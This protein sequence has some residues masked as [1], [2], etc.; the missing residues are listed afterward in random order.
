MRR[1]MACSRSW[2]ELREDQRDDRAEDGDHRQRCRD[3]DAGRGRCIRLF[4]PFAVEAIA[5]AKEG[6]GRATR[7]AREIGDA[8][9]S[10]DTFFER[11]D[12]GA[13]RAD[14]EIPAA[15]IE[16]ETQSPRA[17]AAR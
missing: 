6:R 1:W 8:E 3:N 14:D 10:R 7:G 5:P 12:D 4:R 17:R 9:R 15:C 13:E 16:P 2:S 11:D